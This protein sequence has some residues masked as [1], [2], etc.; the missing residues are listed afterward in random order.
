MQKRFSF[1]SL[2]SE[3]DLQQVQ[4]YF[5][6]MKWHMQ[7]GFLWFI[8]TNKTGGRKARDTVSINKKVAPFSSLERGRQ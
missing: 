5:F 1:L 4:L 8:D 6:A 2:N 3:R 7:N